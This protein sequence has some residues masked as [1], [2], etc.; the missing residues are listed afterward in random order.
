M[1]EVVQTRRRRF[2][3]S[4]RTMLLLVALGAAVSS[5]LVTQINWIGE[6]REFRAVHRTL[7]AVYLHGTC[8]APGALPLFG[9][10][11]IEVIYTAKRHEDAVRRLFPEAEIGITPGWERSTEELR[12]LNGRFPGFYQPT[13]YDE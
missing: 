6:R 13:R 5:W 10:Q 8:R 11:G 9:E 4:L 7:D 2:Q 3:F 12:R 1:F